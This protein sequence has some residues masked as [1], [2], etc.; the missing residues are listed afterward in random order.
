MTNMTLQIEVLA[1]LQIKKLRAGKELPMIRLLY[2][3]SAFRT[4]QEQCRLGAAN[5]Q[6]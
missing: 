1:I 5:H 2:D 3:I 4:V 6:S